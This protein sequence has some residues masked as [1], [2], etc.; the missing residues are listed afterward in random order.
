MRLLTTLAPMRAQT[1]L[2]YLQ[3][4]QATTPR[5]TPTALMDQM[6]EKMPG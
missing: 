2:E 5:L 4:T 3:T 1:L 6:P